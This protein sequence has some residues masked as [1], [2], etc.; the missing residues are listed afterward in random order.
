MARQDVPYGSCKSPITADLLASTYV[1][2]DELRID[3]DDIY[4][5]EHRANDKGRNVI[6]RRKPHVTL[7]DITPPGYSAR[8]RDHEYGVACYLVQ[9]G[10]TYFPTYTDQ[11]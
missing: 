9:N 7:T 6:D 3:G 8:T 2:L 11:L 4:W 5:N 10:T 1:A